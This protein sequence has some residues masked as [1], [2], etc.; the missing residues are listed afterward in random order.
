ML[1][2]LTNWGKGPH[3][4][5]RSPFS[6]PYPALLSSPAARRSSLEERRRPAAEF[7]QDISPGRTSK[8]NEDREEREEEDGL[9]PDD[10][11]DEDGDEEMT[12]L[13]PIFSA[14]HL[15]ALP[16]YNLT[17]TI[18]ILVVPR[19][20]T[21]LSWDQLRSPQVSQFLI[22]P[23]Q[24]Q[25]RAQHFSRATLYALLAN[26]LQFNKEVQ[27]NPGNSGAS[28]TRAL[29]CELLAIKLLKEFSTRELVR[30]NMLT[31]EN[32]DALSYDFFPLQGLVAAGSGALIP[33]PNWDPPQ[34]SKAQPRAARISTLEIAIRAQSKRF[35]AHPLVVQQLEAIWAGSIVFHS[36]ADNLHRS[37]EKVTPNQ[38]RGYGTIGNGGP[39]LQASQDR[40]Q[41]AKQRDHLEP[42]TFTVRRS[43]TLYDP[44][45]ASLFKLSRL[46]VPRYRQFLSTCSFAILLGLY[47]AVLIERSLEITALEV[48]FWFWSAGFMLDEV[49][50]FNE[51]G[52]S[53]YIM[54]FWNTFDVGIL[55]LLACYY[56]MRLYGILMPDVRKH[57]VA[58]M[59]YDLLASNAVLL[60]PR[61]F[62]VLDHYRYFSQLL[63]AFRMMAMDLVAV[64]ILIVISCSGFFVAFTLSFGNGDYDAGAVAYALFQM[65]MGFTPAA[66]DSWP[67]Y[68]M[69]GK[70]IL[71]LFLFICHFLIVTI[72]ITVLTNSFMAV[73][74]NANEEHQFVFAVNAISMVKSDALFSYIA[75]TNIIAWFLT[76][77]RFVLPFRQFVRLNRTV[78]KVTH[79]FILFIIYVY[80]RVFLRGASFEPTDLIEQRGRSGAK[81]SAFEARV[82][83]LSLFSPRQNRLREPSVATFY[84]DR[85]L[86]EVFRRPFR[87][88]TTR[89][90]QKSDER[91]NVVNSWMQSMGPEGTASP[92]KEQDRA[93]LDRLEARRLAHR[94]SQ[95]ALRHR[96]KRERNFTTATM[97]V[98]SDPEDFVGGGYPD[99]ALYRRE[100][101]DVP[102]KQLNNLPEQTDADGDDELVSN[103]EDENTSL[104][105]QPIETLKLRQNDSPT[106]EEGYF[107]HTPTAKAKLPQFSS[108]LSSNHSKEQSH[109]RVT[110]VRGDIQRPGRG[111]GRIPST[112][113]VVHDPIPQPNDSSSSP[114]RKAITTRN[115]A[116][117]TGTGSGAMTPASA[118]R[119]TP[120]GQHPGLVRPLQIMPPKSAF[121]LMELGSD[122]GDNNAVGGGFIGAVPSSFATQMAF[123]TDA[124]RLGQEAVASGN[125]DLRMMVKLLL[126]RMN[127]MDEKFREVLKE[128]KDWRKE[129][130]RSV[131]D[132]RSDMKSGGKGKTRKSTRKDEKSKTKQNLAG[133]AWVDRV[134]RGDQGDQVPQDEKGSSV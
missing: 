78:I 134:E 109:G 71:T 84:K 59:A 25:I 125:E 50:G 56:F 70:G 83:K 74:Q 119:R 113:T 76:P 96:G 38:T 90:N 26:C 5:E 19:C 128:V 24:Q 39:V 122:I 104:D 65:L 88:D 66:W 133:V 21:T 100:L 68:N 34:K 10:D 7:N 107:Q 42:V 106:P 23:I 72:L 55:L 28:K 77:L 130:S 91:S 101:S 114:S 6:S 1:S 131:G 73:V 115:S 89:K 95:L 86:D 127:G 9:D 60:F 126:A 102:P 30:P 87:D 40:L 13:L 93:I 18:R 3:R 117:N 45:D 62:S 120:K 69:L 11:M 16:V 22:K 103:D 49:V 82:G 110:P 12:P 118:G 111:H 53:L 58:D 98:M 20:E 79:F 112:I 57:A 116:K 17:H 32:P 4:E 31:R 33:G 48:V 124:V 51:Q 36:S 99:R 29:V 43:V 85:A 15:D 8:N 81:K 97:S 37:P 35:L 129:E 63:I 52:F 2:S 132:D 14:A 75:P 67:N 44:H 41:P 92:P 105:R 80:E 46:R 123:A 27:M 64:F 108:S 94:Q 61:L 47:L 121:Q 54:S